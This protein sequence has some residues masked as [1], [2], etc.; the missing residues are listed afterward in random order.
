MIVSSLIVIVIGLSLC[1][2]R[3]PEHVVCGSCIISGRDSL[4]GE[5]TRGAGR[6]TSRPNH[7]P[8]KGRARIQAQAACL[9]CEFWAGGTQVGH[10]P[11]SDAGV[12]RA[13]RATGN[14]GLGVDFSD[15]GI[16]SFLTRSAYAITS[17]QEAHSFRSK[18]YW[19]FNPSPFR[20]MGP[21]GPCPSAA[22]GRAAAPA[23]P[24]GEGL[25]VPRR[26]CLECSS[27]LT[28]HSGFSCF[29]K[30]LC[31]SFQCQ[32]GGRDHKLWLPS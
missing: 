11:R 9:A 32:I 13:V 12:R 30:R 16:D 26:S 1:T 14:E 15:I 5:D 25:L 7:T 31:C 17:P 27:A 8:R 29:L 20:E 2:C 19:C 4:P 22:D 10:C 6:L 21:Q 23:V 28:R 18:R 24:R 3:C